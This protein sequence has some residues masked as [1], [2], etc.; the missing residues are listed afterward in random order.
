MKQSEFLDSAEVRELTGFS[1]AAEQDDWLT[2]R[3]IPHRRDGRRIIICRVHAR[4]WV[5][6]RAVVSS[7]GPNWTAVA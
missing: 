5:E 1:R 7:N 3:G 2:N 4:S 6:G